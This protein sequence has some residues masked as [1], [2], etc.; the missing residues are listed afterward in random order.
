MNNI[1][2]IVKEVSTLGVIL[3]SF[4]S[5]VAPQGINIQSPAY[6]LPIPS[7]LISTVTY[8]DLVVEQFLI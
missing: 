8:S 1:Y 3:I 4:V 2:S 7:E 5:A 6:S